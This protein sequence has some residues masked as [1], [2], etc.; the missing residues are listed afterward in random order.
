M[1][2]LLLVCTM[3]YA[4]SSFSQSLKHPKTSKKNAVEQAYAFVPPTKLLNKEIWTRVSNT[5][6]ECKFL[7]LAVEYQ[8]FEF[9]LFEMDGGKREL[10]RAPEYKILG[11]EIAMNTF[12]VSPNYPGSSRTP[13]SVASSY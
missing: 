7:R 9:I 6:F 4:T 1:K 5:R 12:G 13:G 8:N 3:L 2:N 11:E 10:S